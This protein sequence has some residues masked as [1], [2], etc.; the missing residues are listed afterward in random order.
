MGRR[1]GN[2]AV[3]VKPRHGPDRPGEGAAVFDFWTPAGY[4]PLDRRC[5]MEP[6]KVKAYYD[7][8]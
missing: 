6:V 7:F 1:Y 8:R 3:P 5:S 4:N 2:G